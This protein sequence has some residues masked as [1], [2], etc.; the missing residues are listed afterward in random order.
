MVNQT[1]SQPKKNLGVVACTCHPSYEGR[2]KRRI[3][4]QTNPGINARPFLK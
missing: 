1:P 2:V 3:E 4:V